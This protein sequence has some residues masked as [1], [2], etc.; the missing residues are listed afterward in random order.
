V[1]KQELLEQLKRAKYEFDFAPLAEK[2]ERLRRLQELLDRARE[3]TTL[4]RYDL[5]QVIEPVYREY[6]AARRRDEARLMR[7]IV[8][9]KP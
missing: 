6:R 8:G 2:H 1:S 5:L 3:G 9:S 7:R 4:S